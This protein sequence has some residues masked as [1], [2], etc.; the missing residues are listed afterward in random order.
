MQYVILAIIAIAILIAIGWLYF[1]L[2]F[3]LA[4]LW[5][6]VLP[7]CALIGILA[8]LYHLVRSLLGSNREPDD[9]ATPDRV[10]AGEIIK[11]PR[12]GESAHRPWDEAW[13]LYFPYQY[14]FDIAVARR[15]VLGRAIHNVK[16][17]RPS[18]IGPSDPE[19]CSGVI[20]AWSIYGVIAVSI[21]AY[22]LAFAA[23]EALTY[24]V[25]RLLIAIGAAVTSV[26]QQG[27]MAAAHRED[28][29]SRRQRGAHIRCTECF[30]ETELPGF[31]CPDPECGRIHYDLTPGPL[32]IRTR[33]CAC[34][35][36]LPTT[37][38]KASRSLTA[39]C[40]YCSAPLPA[41]AG[42]RRSLIIPV[43]GPVGTGKTHLLMAS[44][45]ALAQWRHPQPEPVEAADSR[46]E[47]FL[48]SAM[49][50]AASHDSPLKTARD[51]SSRVYT[52]FVGSGEDAIEI[53]FV[54]AAGEFFTT[55]EN[56][57]EL[58]YLD[59]APSLV[60]VL[61]PLL[62]PDV[63]AEVAHRGVKLGNAGTAQGSLDDA[64]ASVVDRLRDSG[65]D[66]HTRNLVITVTKSDIVQEAFPSDPLGTSNDEVKTWLTRHGADRLVTEAGFDFNGGTV[67]YLALSNVSDDLMGTDHP[68]AVLRAIAGINSSTHGSAGS[69]VLETTK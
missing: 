24:G 15:A 61:D 27:L 35:A 6:T 38:E 46:S 50:L 43:F 18:K 49:A 66:L 2:L 55:S 23:G 32:G 19:G 41:G 20:F 54:D 8:G 12:K 31:T 40:P 57:H 39:L 14:R 7:V 42:S 69:T 68:L 9:V 30:R 56:T 11:G 47:E 33:T 45:A 34:T 59:H 29:S 53:Q 1:A 44:V 4:G 52:Y 21:S 10:C 51:S 60:F 26:V 22:R 17:S 67:H 64:Y 63:A 65:F 13:P 28:S 58:A 3:F 62:I 37:V 36:V 16:N 5:P 48:R 25:W